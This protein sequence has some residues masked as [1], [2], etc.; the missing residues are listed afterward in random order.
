MSVIETHIPTILANL[1]RD[2]PDAPAY[3]FI[4]YDV[5]PA[6]YRE[7]VTWAQLRNRVRVVAAELAT[8]ASPGDRV[9]ILAP[10]GLDYVAGFFAAIKAGTIAVPLFAPELP[11]H[12]ERLH[13][14][15]AD[16]GPTTVLTT[17]AARAA[18]QREG[19]TLVPLR[20]YFNDRGRAKIEIAVARGKQLHDKRETEK[21]RDWAREKGRLMRDRG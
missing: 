4:D 17:S 14:A 15:L 7:T 3:T 6:G 1:E 21:K 20:V 13:T 16:S 2:K 12:A 8:C 18:V 19:M 11:G 9:A 5:D 10:Q